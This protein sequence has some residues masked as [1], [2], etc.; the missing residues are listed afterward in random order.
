VI[1]TSPAFG[2]P[3][4]VVPSATPASVRTMFEELLTGLVDDPAGPKILSTLGV[5]RF[6]FGQDSDYDGVRLMV[7]ETGLGK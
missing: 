3:P 6:V 5:D 1:D 4:V 7:R 2:I